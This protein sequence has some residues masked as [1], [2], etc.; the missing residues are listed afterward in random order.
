M[1]NLSGGK[2]TNNVQ[3]RFGH[4]RN[5]FP[6]N[7]HELM[8]ARFGEITPF[9]CFNAEP[10]DTIPLSSS[11]D[12]QS[13]TL[14]SP[15]MSNFRMFKSYFAVPM[16]SI[17][18]RAWELIYT[19]PVQGDD[20]PA[21][22]ICVTQN[23]Q[24]LIVNL[25]NIVYTKNDDDTPK[26]SFNLRVQALLMLENILSYGGLPQFLGAN[27]RQFAGTIQ[28]GIGTTASV[29]NPLNYNYGEGITAYFNKFHRDLY[30]D[31]ENTGDAF[32]KDPSGNILC[33]LNDLS[34]EKYRYAISLLRENPSYEI[35]VPSGSEIDPT[36]IDLF[37]EQTDLYGSELDNQPKVNYARLLAYQLA[38]AEFMTNEFVDPIYSALLYRDNAESILRY[39]YPNYSF[40]YNGRTILYDV[41]SGFC[42]NKMITTLASS[43]IQYIVKSLEYFSLIFN[44]R[45]SLK[46]VDYFTSLKTRPLA[47]GDVTSP[48]VSSKVSAVDVTH[49]IQVQRFLNAVNKTGRKFSEYVKGILGGDVPGDNHEPHFISSQP[50]DIS[51][52]EVESTADTSSTSESSNLG[53][54]VTI[55]RSSGGKYE[56]S[57]DVDMP[58]IIIGV[59]HFETARNYAETTDRFFRHSDRFEMFNP[60]MQYIGDQ[61]IG[62]D[63]MFNSP[64][65]VFGYQN[66]YQEYK[67]CFDHASGAFCDNMLPSWGSVES[68]GAPYTSQK[69]NGNI[70]PDFIRSAPAELDRFYLSLTNLSLTDYFHFILS[71]HNNVDAIRSMEYKP[72]IL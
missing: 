35:A 68:T 22:A 7:R 69:V 70:T 38:T 44:F 2:S 71:I 27:L 18:P 57:I 5:K 50:F 17:L 63:E 32:I 58:T 29:W 33:Y 47:I 20:V 56:F 25:R 72:N 64:V 40:T 52:F 41:F 12:I 66:R 53:K 67:Q 23:I 54:R 43:D 31:F 26:Y 37:C 16:Q 19:N 60:F 10:G 62:N 6:F 61:S 46:R 9:F 45:R 3:P 11:H 4:N 30:S 42:F 21:D 36:N 1:K 59:L 48:V 39:N 28:I 14:K 15:L 24:G 8:T 34:A 55:L 51:G 13:Y 49:S 65:G